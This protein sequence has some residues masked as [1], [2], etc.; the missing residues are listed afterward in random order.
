MYNYKANVKLDTHKND[1]IQKT[2]RKKE[3]KKNRSDK[4][5]TNSDIKYRA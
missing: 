2:N 4:Q 1:Q 3:E 5:K